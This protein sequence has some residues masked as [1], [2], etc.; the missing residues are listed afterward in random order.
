MPDHDQRT[1]LVASWER[2]DRFRVLSMVVAVGI[3]IAAAMAV[4]GLPPIDL[5]G[6]PHFVGIMDP[7]CGMTRAAR[8]LA[9]GHVGGAVEYN[10]ASPVLVVLAAGVL[11]RVGVGMATGWW[12]DF[13][14][15]RSTGLRTVF[16][17]AFA[18]LWINQQA[19][20]ALLMRS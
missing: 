4:F 13:R 19:N 14:V 16:W 3:A 1:L 7:F 10:P 8:L 20:A 15:R 9:L 12:L 11:V 2:N 18:A 17:I 6:P 5:H